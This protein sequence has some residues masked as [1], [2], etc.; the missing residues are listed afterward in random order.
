MCHSNGRQTEKKTWSGRCFMII[1]LATLFCVS[2]GSRAFA[3]GVTIFAWIDGD[4]IRTVS[5]FSGGKRVKNS[6]VIIFDT[7][8]NQL[9]EGKTDENGEF[10]CTIPQKTGLKI[11]LKSSMGHMAQW[12]IAAE[13]INQDSIA[14]NESVSV[15]IVKAAEKTSSG[16]VV[17]ETNKKSPN[18][19]MLCLE[20]Q[21]I[22]EL[23]DESL[24]S[25]LTPILK[26]MAGSIDCGPKMTEII[27]G[28]GYIVGLVGVALYFANRGRKE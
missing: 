24:D 12:I 22:R 4:T 19:A 7:Q 27:G 10:S 13:E 20:P 18:P 21:E 2:A 5:K 6:T 25:K 17:T 28:I 23:I 1:F 14:A 8:G 26:M 11:I 16:D 15:P 3:H 9:L